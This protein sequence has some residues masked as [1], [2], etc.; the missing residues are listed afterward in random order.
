MKRAGACSV[1]LSPAH[2]PGISLYVQVWSSEYALAIASCHT[3]NVY[4]FLLLARSLTHR[5]ESRQWQDLHVFW[6]GKLAPGKY[7][8]DLMGNVDNTYGCRWQHGKI[9]V[10]LIGS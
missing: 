1:V 10:A 7:T 4:I 6:T 5:I 2:V 8:A 3:I 9:S